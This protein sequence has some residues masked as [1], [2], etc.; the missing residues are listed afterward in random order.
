V[1]KRI[2]A[3]RNSQVGT[4]VKGTPLKRAIRKKG[5]IERFAALSFYT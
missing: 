5:F 1:D 4:P 3:L 2:K